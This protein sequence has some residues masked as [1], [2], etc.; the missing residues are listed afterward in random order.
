MRRKRTSKPKLFFKILGYIVLI[1]IL[2][3]IALTIYSVFG[4]KEDFTTPIKDGYAIIKESSRSAYI[5]NTKSANKDEPVIN[6]I[7]ISYAISGQ[8]IAVKQTAVPETDDIKP[9]YTTYCYWLIDTANDQISG[10]F[11]SDEDFQTKCQELQLDFAE[12]IGA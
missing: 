11:N 8:Y 2:L 7:V 9:D 4:P 12:W 1:I 6:S 10:S 5:V 3:S